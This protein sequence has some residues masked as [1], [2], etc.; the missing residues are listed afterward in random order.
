MKLT[1]E[2]VLALLPHRPPFLLVD[3]VVDGEPGVSCVAVRT[4]RDDDWWFA[5]HFPGNPVMPGV[6]IVEALAQAATIAAASAGA[7]ASAD[8]LPAAEAAPGGD[9]VGLF[10]GI[11]KI[12][13][14]RVC[15]PGDTLTLE[16]RDHRRARAGRPRQG[17]GHRGGPAGLP[18]RAHVRHRRRGRRR[19]RG[20]EA[21]IG[22]RRGLVRG[23]RISA[24]GVHVPERVLTND[25]I[26]QFLDTS[27]EWITTRTGI[28]ERRIARVDE[29]AS[30]LGEVAARRCLESGGLDAVDLDLVIVTTI[31]PDHIMPATASIVAEKIGAT[32]AGAF[33][34]QAGC[35]G[36]VYGLA[37]ATAFVSANIYENVLVVGAEVL[38][39]MVDW[40]DRG[41]CILFGDGAGAVLVQPTDNG[42]I[43]SFDLG[44]DGSG[45][46]N[47]LVP[48]GGSRMPATFDT[49]RDHEHAMHMTGS[50]VF[51]FATRTVVD[52][53]QKVLSD[54][55]I[56]VEDVDLFVPHQANIRIIESASRRLGMKE[57]QVFANLDRY[58]NT[59]CASIPICLH[60]AS[61][62]GRLKKGDT[63]LMAGFGAGLTWGSC[64]TK[65]EL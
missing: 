41:T 33:D 26:S 6:L 20:R 13:F 53:C 17:Q 30:D 21:V 8:T 1:H 9:K 52:S 22:L 5:G 49:V 19:R 60:E 16:A 65:W 34:V 47:L 31:S 44:N 48:A 4:L 3:E 38:S 7:D 63:L 43:F 15:K 56:G 45:A 27:D 57:S 42:S 18:R 64:L 46:S 10:A 40:E 29:A 23:A 50:E 24:L 62:S 25:E 11:D 2:Q 14:K 12:R 36:F 61:E 58:G 28:R 37:I 51:K 55:E 39:K 59:S 54:A 35:T 32:K